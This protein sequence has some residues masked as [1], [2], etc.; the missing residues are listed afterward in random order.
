MIG[1]EFCTEALKQEIR[2]QGPKAIKDQLLLAERNREFPAVAEGFRVIDTETVT[3]VIPELR[4]RL[5]RGERVT[6]DQ[7][8]SLSVQVW[9]NR[10]KTWGIAT[11]EYFGDLKAW[12]LPYDDFLG[13]MAGVLPLVDAGENSYVV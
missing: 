12:T 8:Q 3:V 11:I 1:P 4:E 9:T 10:V 6:K 13:I 2:R 7:L 5:K